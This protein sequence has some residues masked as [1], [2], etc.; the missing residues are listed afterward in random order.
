MM[1][2]KSYKS[3]GHVDFEFEKGR[4][5][6]SSVFSSVNET[7]KELLNRKIEMSYTGIRRLPMLKLSIEINDN[8]T[9][10]RKL[11]ALR[12]GGGGNC[13]DK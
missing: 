12:K 8:V 10:F 9:I 5:K 11:I 13:H 4:M 7:K 1:K 6:S 2:L 3:I